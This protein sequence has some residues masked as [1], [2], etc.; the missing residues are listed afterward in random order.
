MAQEHERGLGNWQAELA[1]WPGLFSAAHGAARALAEAFG[2]LQV[3][4]GRMRRNIDSLH[5][6]VFAEA[7][8]ALLA[9]AIGKPR[10]Q[11]LLEQLSRRC[12]AEN[13]PLEALVGE[14][15]EADAE[16]RQNVDA[17]ALRA[18]FDPVAAAG[19]ATRLVRERLPALRAALTDLPPAPWAR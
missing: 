15:V 2:G 16:L 13:R 6:L 5:G 10:S 18:A 12:V 7:A 11:P 17:A 4:T 3:D 1:E 14:A 8:S 19:H 9:G